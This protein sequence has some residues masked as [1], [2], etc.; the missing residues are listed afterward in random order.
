MAL[1]VIEVIKEIKANCTG[2]IYQDF[3]QNGEPGPDDIEQD[4]FEVHV[5]NKESLE[6]E[7]SQ[8]LSDKIQFK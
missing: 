2:D 8:A 1:Q 5:D 7:I 4:K 3:Y 6:K